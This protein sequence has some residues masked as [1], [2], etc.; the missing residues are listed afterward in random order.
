M[1]EDVEWMDDIAEKVE[2][3]VQP[4][5]KRYMEAGEEERAAMEVCALYVIFDFSDALH[6]PN[7]RSPKHTLGCNAGTSGMTTATM[8]WRVSSRPSMNT[9]RVLSRFVTFIAQEMH[10]MCE[11]GQASHRND[12]GADKQCSA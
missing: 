11:T 7:S 5:F 9:T 2:R 3:D 8:R 10:L 4:I 1:N 6:R 12:L